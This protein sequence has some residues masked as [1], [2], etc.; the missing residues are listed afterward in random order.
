M[1]PREILD[2][3]RSACSQVEQTRLYA[4]AVR[5]LIRYLRPS[6]ASEQVLFSDGKEAC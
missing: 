5:Q 3:V 4:N 6:G 1:E 2:E